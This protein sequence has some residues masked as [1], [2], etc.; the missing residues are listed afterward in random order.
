[1]RS[2]KAST[3]PEAISAAKS[4]LLGIDGLRE[5][6]GDRLRVLG[7]A[8]RD[9]PARQQTLRATLDWSHALLDVAEQTVFRRLG[10]F[11]GGFSVE[12]AQAV[13]TDATL[14]AWSVLDHLGALVDKSLVIAAG[15][16]P[17]Y[18]LLDT[19]REFALEQLAATAEL[20]ALRRRHAEA[21]A[22]QLAE[23]DRAVASAP[24]FDALV[25][26]LAHELDNLHAALAWA[27]AA[28]D[29]LDLALT[30]AG[31]GDWLWNEFDRYREGLQWCER[32]AARLDGKHDAAPGATPTLEQVARFRLAHAGLS[33]VSLSPPRVWMPMARRALADCRAAGYRIGIY[34][35]LCLLSGPG[36]DHTDLDDIGRYLEEAAALEDPAWAPRLRLRRQNA[37]EWWHDVAGRLPEALEASRAHVALAR[38]A[39]GAVLIGAICNLSD[40]EF[41]VGHVDTAIALVEEAIALAEQ[42]G[43]PAGVFHAYGN[44]V[45]ALLQRG[46]IAPAER[47]IRMGRALFV[48][49]V[50]TAFM[51]LV[52]A[53]LLAQQRGEADLAARLIG[54]ADRLYAV[55]GYVLHP[56][57]QRMRERLFAGLRATPSLPAD[58]LLAL[59]AEGA[60]WSEDEAF[61]RA[62]LA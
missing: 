12:L 51:L 18:R 49:S 15:E 36:G 33:R 22:A 19:T 7:A 42:L 31:S 57:E 43:R 6:L 1:M 2:G 21:L 46:D 27:V 34:R 39:G 14:D 59:Q 50:G 11:V 55:G 28:P 10:I 48:R 45:P 60:G 23:F 56:P 52:P 32:I 58:R 20:E 40:S 62:G 9:A 47:A 35:A 4:P 17:R 25:R 44:I 38:Q 30:L 5:R 37:L 41:S 29:G 13:V 16:P 24:R 26:P 53:A 3:G 54:C 61:A 8:G